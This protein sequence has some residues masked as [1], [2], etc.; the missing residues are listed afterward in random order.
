MTAKQWRWVAPEID[1]SAVKRLSETMKL[2]R[3]TAACLMQRGVSTEEEARFFLNGSLT[4]LADPFAMAGME[5]A[6]QRLANAVAARET[7]L[8]YGDYDADG[9]TSVALLT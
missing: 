8:I 2:H 9:V 7:L 6:V 5:E 4:E 1:W 3:L